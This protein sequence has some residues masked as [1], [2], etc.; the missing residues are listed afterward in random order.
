MVQPPLS[1]CL[2]ERRSSVSDLVETHLSLVAHLVHERLSKVP[3]HVSRDELTSAGLL[4]LV[5]SARNYEP[6]RGVPFASFAAI[7]IRGAL[8]DELRGMDWASR[9]VRCRARDV[10]AVRGQ[11]AAILERSPRTDE[12]ATAMRME[13]R[14]LDSLEADLA[15]ANVLSLQA[16][17][18]DS[19]NDLPPE[20]SDGPES[21]ILR[22][23]QLGYLHDAVAELP[24]RLR[25]VIDAY[26]FEHRP[27]SDIAAELGVTQS[28]VS[29]MCTEALCLLRDG[30][31]SQLDPGAL[32]QA[33][34][35]TRTAATRKAYFSAIA[36]RGTL[37]SRLAMSTPRGD[38]V[39]RQRVAHAKI[40]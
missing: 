10:E 25:F 19:M 29:Q 8:L 24:D 5:L 33:I 3:A 14:E 9:S 38:V 18:P 39:D 7:R 26:Y 11:L 40:A 20:S 17:P 1:V 30:L 6:D 35:T 12:V 13:A 32:R 36:G 21:L 16:F 34:Q 31:N 27:M 28:R 4:A 2:P 22:R 37:T 23:E 15:R